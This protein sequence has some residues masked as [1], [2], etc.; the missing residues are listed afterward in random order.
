MSDVSNELRKRVEAGMEEIERLADEIR[1]RLHLGG[2]DAKDAWRK[3]EP[4]LEDARQHAKAATE[5]SGKAIEDIRE[6]F[7]KLRGSL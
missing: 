2:M 6:A 7:K 5:A 1:V 4:Q 3:L